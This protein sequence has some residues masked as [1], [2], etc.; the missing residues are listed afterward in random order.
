MEFRRIIMLVAVLGAAASK[1]YAQADIGFEFLPGGEPIINQ[2]G[3]G[4]IGPDTFRAWGVLLT[5]SDGDQLDIQP[6]LDSCLTPPNAL[7]LCS[8]D[9]AIEMTFVL[10]GTNIPTVV[11]AIDLALLTS[12]G[13]SSTAIVNIYNPQGLLLDSWSCCTEVC[14]QP[15]FYYG[16]HGYVAPRSI[17]TIECVLLRAAIDDISVGVLPTATT[18][19]TWGAI[20]RAYR[21]E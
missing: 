21:D 2:P 8:Q 5:P 4:E 18:H 11:D 1:S 7:G 16:H 14:V 17:A 19:D 20:K 10:P 6:T 15:P 9:G 3:C 13:Q 12:S